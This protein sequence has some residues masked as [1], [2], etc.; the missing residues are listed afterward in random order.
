VFYGKRLEHVSGGGGGGCAVRQDDSKQSGTLVTLSVIL[1]FT[2]ECNACARINLK[3]KTSAE[4][5][6]HGTGCC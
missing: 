2:S 5:R 6:V 1:S 4:L 3:E